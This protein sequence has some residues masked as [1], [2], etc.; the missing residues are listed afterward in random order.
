MKFMFGLQHPLTCKP[1]TTLSNSCNKVRDKN[2]VKEV[3]RRFPSCVC[4]W[5]CVV[6][7]HE[8]VNNYITPANYW[9]NLSLGGTSIKFDI[10][11]LQDI[12]SQKSKLS[13]SKNKM[14]AIFQDGR[15]LKLYESVWGKVWW[16]NAILTFYASKYMFFWVRKIHFCIC[17]IVIIQN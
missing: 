16:N 4:F 14:A 1:S 13:T 17:K 15:Y 2:F 3:F 8:R 12:F 6:V 9:N 11:V 10:N 7:M 5:C